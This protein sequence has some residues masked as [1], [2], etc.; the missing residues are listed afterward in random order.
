MTILAKLSNAVTSHND[1]RNA[2][3]G[4]WPWGLILGVLVVGVLAY[5]FIRSWM[6]SKK[7]AKLLHE[8]AVR[9]EEAHRAEV[10]ARIMEVDSQKERYLQRKEELENEILQLDLEIQELSSSHK[11]TVEEIR[12]IESW[13]DV[14]A[15]LSRFRK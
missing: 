10:M 1:K 3:V 15:F 4:S 6:K 7:L 8:K 11:L 13:D 2:G 14:E 12:L 9:E 5:L